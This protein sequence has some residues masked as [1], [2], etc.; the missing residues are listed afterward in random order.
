MLDPG[1]RVTV[2]ELPGARAGGLG[3]GDV[4]LVGPR[5]ALA[6]PARDIRGCRRRSQPGRG[7]DFPE[8]YVLDSVGGESGAGPAERQPRREAEMFGRLGGAAEDQKLPPGPRVGQVHL[9]V[10]AH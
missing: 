6:E 7:A 3:A 10:I 2:L 1:G 8:A 4:A 5:A 9:T